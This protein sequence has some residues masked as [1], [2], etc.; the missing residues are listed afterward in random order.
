MEFDP[1]DSSNPECNFDTNF[2]YKDVSCW[3]AF[4]LINDTSLLIKDA[5]YEF[6]A[7]EQL[8]NGNIDVFR[9]T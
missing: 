5:P 9:W 1:Y 7:F 3:A 6:M 4:H 8:N 2:V